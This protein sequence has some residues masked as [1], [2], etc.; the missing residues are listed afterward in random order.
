MIGYYIIYY[1]YYIFVPL[2]QRNEKKKEKSK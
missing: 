1:I 2:R